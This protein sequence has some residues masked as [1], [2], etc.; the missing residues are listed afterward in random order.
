M[1][2]PSPS[3]PPSH[4]RRD[5]LDDNCLVRAVGFPRLFGL[6]STLSPSRTGITT[7][8]CFTLSS[9][10]V[11]CCLFPP[12]TRR[13]S[14]HCTLAIYRL[15][16]LVT[17]SLTAHAFSSIKTRLIRPSARRASSQPAL[18]PLQTQSSPVFCPLPLTFSRPLLCDDR[19]PETRQ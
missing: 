10:F 8:A 13:A 7:S 12:S 5:A 9:S 4:H 18:A 1:Q 6:R 11:S 15:P 2:A 17:H 19:T 14:G 3:S 16:S